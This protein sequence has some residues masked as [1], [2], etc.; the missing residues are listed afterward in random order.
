MSATFV[1]PEL[2]TDFPD[3]FEDMVKTYI[4]TEYSI[5][6]PAKTDTEHFKIK[7]GFF[8]YFLPYEI[9]IVQSE[10]APPTFSNSGRRAYTGTGI[11]VGIRMQRLSRDKVDKQLGKMER[12]IIRIIMQYRNQDIP[13]IKSFVWGGGRRVYDANDSWAESDW[14][15]VVNFHLT[16]EKSDI[17]I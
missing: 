9:A 15:A 13:G 8:D 12:E 14:R 1:V 6:D 7:V 5:V 4:E 3:D 16:Y 10:T 11:Q 2:G 17:S